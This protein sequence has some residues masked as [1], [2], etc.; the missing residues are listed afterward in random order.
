MTECRRS[1]RGT[2]C[3]SL[4]RD[5]VRWRDIAPTTF[6]GLQLSECIRG[7]FRIRICDGHGTT[8]RT[9]PSPAPDDGDLAKEGG[10]ER[11]PIEPRHI[12]RGN[13]AD[14]VQMRAI[15]FGHDASIGQMLRP[16]PMMLLNPTLSLDSGS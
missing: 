3:V 15:A 9:D 10:L 13:D 4:P 12:L 5:L 8:T 11:D 6:L 2:D 16:S 14:K 1:G 7:L